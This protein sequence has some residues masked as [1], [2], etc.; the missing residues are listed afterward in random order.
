[1]PGDLPLDYEWDFASHCSKYFT[2]IISFNSPICYKY[3]HDT[4]NSQL[5]EI[6]NLLCT[7]LYTKCFT[8]FNS[9]CPHTNLRSKFDYCF[10]IIN[11]ELEAQK[12]YMTG[13]KS[14]RAGIET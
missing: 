13:P 12:G 9:F 8:Y 5:E 2:Y 1:M 7:R 11:K 4:H 3:N 14:H 10:H 6:A